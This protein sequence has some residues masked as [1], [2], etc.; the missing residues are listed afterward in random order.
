[1][2]EQSEGANSEKDVR[3]IYTGE[4]RREITSKPPTSFNLDLFF[5]FCT[6]LFFSYHPIAKVKE[7]DTLYLI[8]KEEILILQEIQNRSRWNQLR[9]SVQITSEAL[10]H[11][12]LRLFPF[13]TTTTDSRVGPWF[14]S[15]QPPICF[16]EEF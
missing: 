12:A 11:F 9:Q 8:I 3:N 14:P 7:I 5:P 6:S 1:M 15:G 10:I 16:G 13:I 2:P 4:V